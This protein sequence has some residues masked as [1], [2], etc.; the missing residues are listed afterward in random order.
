MNRP[1]IMNISLLL[2]S[3]PQLDKTIP[4]KCIEDKEISYNSN[5]TNGQDT[6]AYS[7]KDVI[8]SIHFCWATTCRSVVLEVK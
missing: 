8:R 6:R 3:C 4:V 1:L 5:T 2:H 7:V